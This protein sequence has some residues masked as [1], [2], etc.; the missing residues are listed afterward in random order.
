MIMA[1]NNIKA[2]I[3]SSRVFIDRMTD[4]LFITDKNLK[5]MYINKPAL[6][7]LGYSEEEVVGK[8][9]CADL[10]R[11]PLCNTNNCTIKNCIK[12][13]RAVVGNTV[14]RTRSGDMFPIRAQCNVIYDSRGNPVG[15]FEY[16]SDVRTIDE[17]FL[18]NMADAAFRTDKDLIVQNIND[19]ALKA[20]GY[21]KEEVIGKMTCADVCRTPVCGTVNCT[22]KRAMEHKTT[23]VATTVA[24]DRYGKILPIRASCGYTS[25]VEGNPTGGFEVISDLL[26]IDEGFLSNMADAA[27]RTDPELIVQNINNAALN[28]LGYT[29][30]EVIG[31]MTCADLCQT[32]ACNT[33]NCTIKR[34]MKE[35]S[36]VIVTTVAKTKQGQLIPVRASC[37]YLADTEGNPT[38]GFEIISSVNQLD[39]GF[40]AN[41]ADAAFRTD[42]DLIVQNINDAA[43]KALG[44]KREEVIGKMTCADVCRTPV[45]GTADCTIRR[46]IETKGTV[47]AETE[48]TAR[49]GKKLPI[50]ASCGVLLDQ[51][52]N[53]SGG[54]EVISDNSA[55]MIMVDK[56]GEISKGDLTGDVEEKYKSRDDA[57]GKLANAFLEM[58]DALNDALGQVNSAVEQVSSG[59]GQVSQSSQ[60]LSQGASEQ[61]SSLE[62]ISSSINQIS[63]QSKQ[64][65]DNATEAN[66]LSK[67]ATENAEAG[68]MK[69][70]ELVDS[71]E[72]INQSSDEIKKVVKVIDDI[73]FQINL[74]ALNANVEAARA[75][76]YGKGFAV[77]A[78]EVRNLAVKSAD[79]VK[80]TTKMVEE[81]I[82][83]IEMGSQAAESTAKQL[84]EIVGG[85]SKVADLVEE[86]TSASKEQ[87]QGIDQ[88]NRGL[89]QVDQVTQSNTANAEESASAAEELSS[90]A[91]QLRAMLTRFKIKENGRA[92]EGDKKEGVSQELLHRLVQEE[93]R[94]I[95]KREH[96]QALLAAQKSGGKE[97]KIHGT[98][99][100]PVDPKKVIKLDDDDFGKF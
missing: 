9:T 39:E 82:K 37:G 93:L 47:V 96:E 19:A 63:S 20:L 62:E 7:V 58:R 75:G 5:V 89:E 31:K 59:S 10:C 36:T 41:M 2:V 46:C 40:L 90:Q 60:S 15:G 85:S 91:Q 55:L 79:S 54:F 72:K 16:I 42:R 3:K 13:G 38:G 64:N 78:E 67:K 65:A 17:G 27:F 76:K 22:I 11:T 77:V 21:K 44:Y 23:V 100:R 12:D 57:V 73:A 86:I 71:M 92:V 66:S 69:M 30:E 52:G 94:K 48:A 99:T 26:N 6:D 81:S 74:L 80:E 18:N 70:K 34:A 51:H 14:A 56:M 45:C 97:K 33:A 49:D 35:K 84:E 32:P 98:H 8:M 24:Q 4:P 61:A 87:A 25:D 68:N 83:N 88:I 29:R 53:P 1:V 28:V 95:K 43:L 50:R